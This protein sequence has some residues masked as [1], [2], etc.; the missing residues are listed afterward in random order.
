MSGFASLGRRLVSSAVM[1]AIAVGALFWLPAVALAA[2]LTA[3]A[4]LA[5]LEFFRLLRQGGL[6]AYPLIGALAGGVLTWDIAWV[7][8][9]GGKDLP[10][11]LLVILPF[12]VMAAVLLRTLLG[13]QSGSPLVAGALTFL[14]LIYLPGL[15]ASLSLLLFSGHSGPTT[16]PILPENR[17]LFIYLIAVVKVSDSG[18]YFVGARWGRRKLIPRVSP[19][20]TWEGFWGGLAAGILAGMAVWALTRGRLG[21][22]AFTALDALAIGFALSLAGVAGDLVESGMKRSVNAKDSGGWLP[23]IGGILDMMDSLL[24]AAPFLYAYA[25]FFLVP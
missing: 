2:M 10:S 9:N 21:G 15:F 5:M 20:K 12:A 11:H 14:A 6:P 8:L 23:G 25:R 4:V 24:F 19:N 17:A 16:R 18:A 3:M 13:R 7:V 22:L 1:I